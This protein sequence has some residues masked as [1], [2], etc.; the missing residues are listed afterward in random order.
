MLPPES[1]SQKISNGL[2]Y[3][4]ARPH[5]FV[6]VKIRTLLQKLIDREEISPEEARDILEWYEKESEIPPDIR[7]QLIGKDV[8]Y[9]WLKSLAKLAPPKPTNNDIVKNLQ[10]KVNEGL[11]KI[12]NIK[13]PVVIHGSGGA[14]SPGRN[15]WTP[16]LA[17][18]A[19]AGGSYLQVVGWTGGQ[20][21]EPE[22]GLYVG[23][24][25]FVENIADATN[26]RGA[27]GSG[28]GGDSFQN[29]FFQESTGTPDI[30]DNANTDDYFMVYQKIGEVGGD[31]IFHQFI[32]I[33]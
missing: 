16:E 2:R 25:G 21:T 5:L 12:E 28:G 22:S 31:S 17:V 14:G 19:Y 8:G 4:N 33:P 6:P 32:W 13:H 24:G 29:L 9:R 23:P 7:L 27:A 11:E 3:I 20:G 1:L 30:P 10:K 26:I 15:G 18:V